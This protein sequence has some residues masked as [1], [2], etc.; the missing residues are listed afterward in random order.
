VGVRARGTPDLSF[1]F[2]RLCFPIS[3]NDRNKNAAGKSASSPYEG[4]RSA[5][6][7]CECV[8]RDRSRCARG[9]ANGSRV[10]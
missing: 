7:A 10:G 1:S 3:N 9:W 6:G 5:Q 2:S 8:S 4:E